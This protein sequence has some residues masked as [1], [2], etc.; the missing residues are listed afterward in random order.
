M[1][2]VTAAHNNSGE[3]LLTAALAK[4]NQEQEGKM[5]LALID[6]AVAASPAASNLP[7]PTANLGNNINI[8][9]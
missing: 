5:A 1:S 8:K 9:A 6:A 3:Q 4:G 7:A 2:S